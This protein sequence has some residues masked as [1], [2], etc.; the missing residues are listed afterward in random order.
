MVDIIRLFH[1]CKL[2]VASL[3]LFCIFLSGS[4]AEAI[5]PVPDSHG[6]AT[7]AQA[8]LKLPV[9]AG[10]LNTGAHPDDENSGLL[11]YVSQGM[12]VRTAYMSLTRGEGGQNLIGPELYDGIGIIR[13]EELLAAHRFDGA[14]QYFTRA[15][16]FGYSKSMDETLEL[17]GHDMILGDVVRVIRTFRPDVVVSQYG[18]VPSDGHGHHQAAGFLTREA[19]RAAADPNQFPEQ[20]A[21]GLHPWQARKLYIRSGHTSFPVLDSLSI[22]TGEYSPV[23]QRSYR[24]LGLA[25]R[26]MHRSQDMGT[27]QRKGPATT[28]IKLVDR[29]LSVAET[30]PD[31]SLFDGID[32]SFLRLA[33]M[34]GAG[35]KRIP[36][37]EEGLRLIDTAAQEA[38]DA[39]RSFEPTGVLPA[40]LMG[41]KTLRDVRSG[42]ASSDIGEADKEHILFLLDNKER[43]FTDV[44]HLALGLSFD[45]LSTDPVVIPGSTFGVDMQLLNRSKIEI[46]PTRLWLSIPEG[47]T[48]ASLKT[49]IRPIGYNEQARDSLA[50]TVAQNAR[51]SKPYWRRVS[52]SASRVTVDSEHLIGLPWRPQAVVGHALFT[53][54]GTP[55]EITQPVQFRYADRA[56]GEIRRQVLVAPALSVTLTPE[57]AVIPTSGLQQSR[58]FQVTVRNNVPGNASVIVRLELP[59]G[60]SSSP[61]A[62]P[63][64]FA[65]EDEETT[66]I[67]DV[68]PAP[69]VETGVYRID[70]LAEWNGQT[71]REGYTEI[72][73]PHIETRHLYRDATS[74]VKVSDVR[75]AGDL[76]VGYIMGAGDGIPQALEQ[77]GVQVHM[78]ESDDLSRGDLNTYDVIVA[79]IRAYEVRRDLVSL[80]H[81]LLEY[82]REG[83]TYIVQ[84][85][86]Y[87]FNGAQYGPYPTR[88][89]R[90]HDRVTREEAPVTILK[91]DHPVF[92][93]PNKIVESDFDGWVQ[94][95]GLYF[96]GEWDPKYTP[97]MSSND[98]GEDP[99]HGGLVEARYGKGRYIYTGYAW[100][101]QL[102]AGVP[103][104]YRIF[105][106]LLSLPKTQPAP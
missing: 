74:E 23:F 90:P 46:V 95:R 6:A 15:F 18:G 87:A 43:D 99:K 68:T 55:I 33:A 50:V 36:S 75:I 19:F 72:A 34:A 47:W 44:V 57:N 13:T 94:E 53:V 21:E 54:D 17:W 29:V 70:A 52:G 51:L 49:D 58:S 25:G 105:A 81:R 92:N 14:G 79:G 86:K 30:A 3:L 27:I 41:L 78:L 48:T 88:I 22:D 60:W 20:I 96:L 7:L 104:A 39:Y 82:V 2:Q 9:V 28:K 100:F 66:A 8:L 11:A 65:R 97:L 102:P 89:H 5:R 83:G 35:A 91:P 85:N 77:L 12:H 4:S 103:G 1:R 80:N 64:D 40:T 26:S 62:V 93:V 16:D 45:V 61:E 101:R 38:I 71:F 84:Y 67:F 56:F 32:T 73:Y 42:I 69:S 10:L 63:W 106:N 98:P 31:R 37:L 59:D 24:E 76:N